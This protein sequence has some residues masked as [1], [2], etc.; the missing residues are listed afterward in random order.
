MGKCLNGHSDCMVWKEG[1]G[2]V[3]PLGGVLPRS[4]RR[5]TDYETMR[6]RRGCSPNGATDKFRLLPRATPGATRRELLPRATRSRCNKPGATPAYSRELLP[7]QQAGSYSRELIPVQQAP[8]TCCGLAITN[9]DSKTFRGRDCP[10]P[11]SKPTMLIS[12][13]RWT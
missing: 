4:F 6:L 11:F 2:D 7:V 12:Q 1:R 10:G 3:G 9:C 13:G 8:K 5:H